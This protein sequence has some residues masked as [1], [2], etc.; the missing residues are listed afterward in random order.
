MTTNRDNAA[1]ENR[2]RA[3]LDGWVNAIRVKDLSGVMSAY[4]P[5]A[6]AFDLD[7]AHPAIAVRAVAGLGGIAQMRQLDAGAAGGA[8]NALAV[9]DIDLAIID[10]EGGC[11]HILAHASTSSGRLAAAA[12]AAL[13]ARVARPLAGRMRVR[14]AL[15]LTNSR[16]AFSARR[17]NT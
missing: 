14:R 7:H 11:A 13:P 17:E 10:G 2:I 12:Q 4:A 1:E 6:L 9:A 5:D 16:V 3:L 8:K 15:P